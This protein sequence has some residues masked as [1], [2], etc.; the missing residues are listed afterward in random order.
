M[1]VQDLS[2]P[3]HFARDNVRKVWRV[4]YAQ[5]AEQAEAWAHTHGIKPASTDSSRTCLMLVDCQNTFCIP[6]FELFVAGSSGMGAV[7]DST[8]LCEFIYRNIG[9]LTEIAATLDTHMAMQI[10]H[11]IFWVDA[12]GEHPIGGQ[13]ILTLDTIDQ[14]EWRVNP[15]VHHHMAADAPGELELYA[16]HYVK[17]LT[18]G[19]KYPLMI[20]PYHA[21]LGG[22]GHALVS[23]V[24]EALFFHSITRQ[25][26]TR[27]E[28]KGANPLTENYSVLRPEVL[29]DGTG[30]IIAEKNTSFIQRLLDF[31][32]VIVAGQAKSHCVAWSVADLLDE[33][34]ERDPSLAGKI[35]LLEDCTSPVVIRGVVDFTEPADEAFQGFAEA[36]MHLVQSTQ[37]VHEW[38][39]WH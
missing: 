33:V 12:H 16:R 19:G 9:Q 23:A 22:I 25:C 32:K 38:P 15:A 4:P 30:K 26:Q 24:E 36:G 3:P 11:P 17:T 37:P 18:L 6:G 5:R 7:E 39:G 31:D 21:M 1:K 14:G 35:Y 8:R 28:T 20:W 2:I 34:R 27:F 10:F 29:T 13:T